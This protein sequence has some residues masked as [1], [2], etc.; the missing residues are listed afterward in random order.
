M[1]RPPRWRQRFH[2]HRHRGTGI[3]PRASHT[4]ALQMPTS[5]QLDHN[6]VR[7]E[8]GYNE[9]G[10]RVPP[11]EFINLTSG[12]MNSGVPQNVL[13]VDPCHMSSLHNP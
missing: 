10:S 2:L 12:A 3:G 11:S 9:V 7:G 13:V 5:P 8:S 6:V 1:V 4:S